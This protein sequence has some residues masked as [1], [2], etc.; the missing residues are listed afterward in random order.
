VNAQ[1]PTL[2]DEPAPLP[3]GAIPLP[4]ATPAAAPTYET[5]SLDDALDELGAIDAYLAKTLPA[6]NAAHTE[7]QKLLEVVGLRMAAQGARKYVGTRCVCRYETQRLGSAAIPMAAGLRAELLASAKI[8]AG[9]ID[10][11][12]PL[13]TPPPICKPD[14]RRV[15][16]LAD[17]GDSI[18]DIIG[19]HIVEARRIE[20]LVVEPVELNVTPAQREIA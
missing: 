7:R 1:Q 2:L 3:V 6:V 20:R 4:I 19:R 17:Y 9:E 12:L 16:K 11:A 5:L 13:V 15:R 18:A 8:P 10:S 14:L